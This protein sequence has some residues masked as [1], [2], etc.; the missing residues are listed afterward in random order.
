MCKERRA[1]LTT[2]KLTGAEPTR[3]FSLTLSNLQIVGALFV[4]AI[5]IISAAIALSWWLGKI[6]VHQEFDKALQEFHTTAKPAIEEVIDTKIGEHERRVATEYAEAREDLLERFAAIEEG[7]RQREARL[8]RI[9][10]K[11]DRL[12]ERR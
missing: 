2:A 9:E 4:H 5:T 10:N 12:L 6:M 11:L 8:E 7:A 1:T 3:G